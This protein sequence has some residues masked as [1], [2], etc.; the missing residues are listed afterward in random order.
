MRKAIL[1]RARRQMT[2]VQ[3]HLRC[4]PLPFVDR[5][6]DHVAGSQLA[7]GVLDGYRARAG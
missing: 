1:D 4:Q 7:V 6:G 3:K 5:T 2:Q